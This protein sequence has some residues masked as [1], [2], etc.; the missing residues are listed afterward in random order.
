MERIWKVE[1]ATLIISREEEEE[2]EEKHETKGHKKKIKTVQ[3][4][5]NTVL[6]SIKCESISFTI[7]LSDV[8][9]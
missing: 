5:Q 7:I 2:E 6:G 8:K 4:I 1:V 9:L 3:L